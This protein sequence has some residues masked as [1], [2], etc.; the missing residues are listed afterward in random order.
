MAGGDPDRA[1]NLPSVGVHWTLITLGTFVIQSPLVL[2]L[3]AKGEFSDI[4]LTP[5]ALPS[6][7]RWHRR[8]RPELQ[9]LR[10]TGWVRFGVVGKCTLWRCRDGILGSRS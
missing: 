7:P 6:L 3:A 8:M 10:V 2:G 1:P 9:G 4:E 5:D